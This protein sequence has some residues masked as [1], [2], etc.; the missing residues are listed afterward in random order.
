MQISR[1]GIFFRGIL[2]GVAEIVPGISGGSVAFITGIYAKLVSS[3]ASF[4]VGSIRLLSSP[5][6]FYQHHNLNFLL[7]L[8]SGMIIGV[9]V[10]SNVMSFLL[11]G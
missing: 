1:L 10:F 11:K 3:I 8:F 7:T 2:M 4:G 6:A 5:K 9:L